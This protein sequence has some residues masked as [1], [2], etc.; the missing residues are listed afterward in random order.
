MVVGLGLTIAG[1]MMKG[2]RYSTVAPVVRLEPAVISVGPS[3]K[4][5]IPFQEAQPII[6]AHRYDLPIELRGK[7]GVALQSAWPVWVLRHDANIRARLARGDEDSIV[8]FWYYGTSFTD[9]PRATAKDLTAFRSSVTGDDALAELLQRRLDELVVGLAAPGSNER[10][11][12]ARTVVERQG[13]DL[14]TP[15]GR[16]QTEQYLISAGTRMAAETKHYDRELLDAKR[17]DDQGVYSTLYRT[18][19]LSSD[20]SILVDFSVEQALRAIKVS[21]N[22]DGGSLRRVAIVGP[23][24]DF[25]DKAEGYDFY[26]QQSLQPFALIDSLIRLGLSAPRNLQITTFDLSPRV[27]DHLEAARRHALHGEGYVVHLP[28]AAQGPRRQWSAD[29]TEYWQHFGDR[30]GVESVPDAT[31]PDRG[32]QVRAVRVSPQTVL[33]ITPQD[34]N[35]VVERV[36]TEHDVDGFDLI[37][38]TNVLLYYDSFEQSLALANVSK[39]LRPGGF[40]L[41]N[42]WTSASSAMRALP[43]LT[44]KVYWHRDQR[45]TGDSMF[46]YQRP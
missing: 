33:S 26:A 6:E 38:A 40:L 46:W 35:I 5:I 18:R 45:D 22:I 14:T 13:I 27:N 15:A 36:T 31:P 30:I 12:F 21:A 34:L 20:T 44:T 41:T 3:F 28:L 2:D 43:A 10:L 19:G 8:N 1:I 11:E 23:G 29:L 17:R 25:T 16:E 9:L 39:M 42:Y 24:L 32:V 37:V 4:T 7:T